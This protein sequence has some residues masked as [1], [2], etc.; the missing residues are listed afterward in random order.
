MDNK[1]KQKMEDGATK[2]NAP[3]ILVV[4]WA[5]IMFLN[6]RND[7]VTVFKPNHINEIIESF[8]EPLPINQILMVM[9][10]LMIVANFFINMVIM[11][12]TNI[13]GGILYILVNIANRIGDT[14]DSYIIYTIIET[15]ITVLIIIRSINWPKKI[16]S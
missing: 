1:Y 11:K 13:I 8:I 3:I 15:T 4:G 14:W 2:L 5:I 7:I 10:I 6:I 16:I 12:W 9:P